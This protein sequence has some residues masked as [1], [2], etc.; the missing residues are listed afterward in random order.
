MKKKLF[1]LAAVL[2]TAVYLTSCNTQKSGCGQYSKWE[3]KTKF[4]GN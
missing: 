3:A 1:I 2:M 4:R